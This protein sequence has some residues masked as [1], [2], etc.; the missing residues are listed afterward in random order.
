MALLDIEIQCSIQVSY[1]RGATGP[2]PISSPAHQ[3]PKEAVGYPREG[4]KRAKT[5]RIGIDQTSQPQNIKQ[6][7][8]VAINPPGSPRQHRDA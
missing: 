6:N 8:V 4:A 5:G 3:S 2:A 7:Q 1:E